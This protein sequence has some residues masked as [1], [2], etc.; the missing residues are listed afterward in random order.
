MFSMFATTSKPMI[1][2]A[3]EKGRQTM[4]RYID[5][6][7][8]PYITPLRQIMAYKDDIDKMPT[9]D[10]VEVVRCK[11][12]KHRPIKEDA[13]GE[14]YGFNLIEPNDG[15]RLCPC[16]VSDGW[17]SWMPKDDFYCGFGERETDH[18]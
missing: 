15:D 6:D 13:D 11:D 12:C 18:E 5:A 14:N 4:S 1:S 2:V 10:A 9:I 17:Y 3:T 16:L 7:K 8:V